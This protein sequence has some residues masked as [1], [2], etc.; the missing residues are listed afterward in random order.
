MGV[1]WVL[2]A[3]EEPRS[4][5]LRGIVSRGF[6]I[7]H[8]DE[9]EVLFAV[10]APRESA[11]PELVAPLRL[12]VLKRMDG[13]W[14]GDYFTSDEAAEDPVPE[15]EGTRLSAAA[16]ASLDAAV[17]ARDAEWPYI[18]QHLD[19][20]GG[21]WITWSGERARMTLAF[22]ADVERHRARLAPAIE[23]VAHRHTEDELEAMATKALNLVETVRGVTP[24]LAK[25]DPRADA[26]SVEVAA[27]PDPA[28]DAALML[29]ERFGDA[30]R[31]D[32][33]ASEP[34]FVRPAA[35]HHYSV[36]ESGLALTVFWNSGQCEPLPLEISETD[37]HVTVR[38]T[39]RRSRGPTLAYAT[40]RRASVALARP[41][42]DRVVLDA[43]TGTPRPP[44]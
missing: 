36:D 37:D 11:V 31:L 23:V 41:L 3:I 18:S 35:F 12:S 27:A 22:I 6:E 40:G 32:V 19:H 30:V 9:R 17:A 1:W 8:A 29:A 44:A 38:V 15:P 25:P 24:F 16:E 5:F 34:T 39:E 7:Q 43:L 4:K 14:S 2:V 21:S 26:A 28:A 13:G 20:Y 33:V 42:N 10:E